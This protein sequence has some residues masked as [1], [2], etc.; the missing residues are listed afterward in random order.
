MAMPKKRKTE[1]PPLIFRN[2][3]PQNYPEIPHFRY[4][5]FKC[6]KSIKKRKNFTEYKK[7]SQQYK[8]IKTAT[9]TLYDISDNTS[10]ENEDFEQDK[11]FELKNRHN[12]KISRALWF[13]NNEK[14]NFDLKLKL[15]LDKQICS[16]LLAVQSVNGID[17]SN[18]YKI[19]N[20]AQMTKTKNSGV[21]GRKKRGHAINSNDPTANEV[22]R[23]YDVSCYLKE[24]LF[25]NG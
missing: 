20:I 17:I 14:I 3:I 6:G 15:C 11:P 18:S 23:S 22:N 7:I 12:S 24:L 10:D 16:H 21:T 19:P 1:I 5:V 8:S 4:D 25:N 2:I 13:I 9:S